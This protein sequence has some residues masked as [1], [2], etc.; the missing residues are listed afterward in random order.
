MSLRGEVW[1]HTTD[2]IPKCL[3]QDMKVGVIYLCSVIDFV[4]FYDFVY[5]IIYSV[6]DVISL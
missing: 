4:S 6:V 1:A 3:N 2:S 5:Y